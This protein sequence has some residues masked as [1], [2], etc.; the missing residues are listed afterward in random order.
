MNGPIIVRF[1]R[2][3]HFFLVILSFSACSQLYFW[4]RE[5]KKPIKKEFVIY[6]PY[7]KDFPQKV[8]KEIKP[9]CFQFR[10][11]FRP[12]DNWELCFKNQDLANTCYLKIYRLQKNIRNKGASK[13]LYRPGE[14]VNL[15]YI[16]DREA[17]LNKRIYPDK[18]LA[19]RIG[20]EN[21]L[22]KERL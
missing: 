22:K 9:W 12:I 13:E 21:L 8:R 3:L 1:L 7:L 20:N 6:D 16:L 18:C 11:Q 2:L 19:L 10:Q 4:T 5:V 17:Y 15:H 14:I